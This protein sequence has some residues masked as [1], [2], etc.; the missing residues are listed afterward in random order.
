MPVVIQT[1]SGAGIA[2]ILP[3]LARLRIAVFREW[4][5]LYDG[6]DPAY[7]ERYLD[8]YVRS[9]AAAIVTAAD[10][11][12]IVGA[13]SCL[14]LRDEMACIRA[15]FEVR[16][17]DL[18]RFFYFG[19]SVLLPAWRGQGLGVRF[20]AERERHA[21]TGTAEFAVFCAVRR[22][23]TH[24]GRPSDA[25]SL[26]GFWGR[27]GFRP[28]PGISCMLDWREPG[29]T[30]ERAHALD[31]WIKPLRDAPVPARLLDP[32]PPDHDPEGLCP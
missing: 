9:P 13:S 32:A 19:E 6:G 15:P 11:G 17:L 3:D 1:R 25:P 29:D 4:P 8:V 14:P 31:F 26:H 23:D 24:P 16:G 12:R 5:Y 20:F 2:A 18:D 28:L 21:R 22:P 7:E 30:A 10:G 27:R